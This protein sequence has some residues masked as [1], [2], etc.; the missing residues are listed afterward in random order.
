DL[1]GRLCPDSC[2]IGYG[3]APATDNRFCLYSP[4]EKHYYADHQSDRSQKPQE[5]FQEKIHK[6]V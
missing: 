4:I 3:Y 5:N 1:G 2:L 6:S